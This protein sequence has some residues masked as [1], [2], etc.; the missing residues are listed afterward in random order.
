MIVHG[1][2]PEA[3][4]DL[5]LAWIGRH[6]LPPLED[7]Q[8]LVQS[9]G[10]AQWLK[11]AFARDVGDGG[12]GI[13]AGLQMSLPSRF[14]WTAYRAVLG[15]DTV[16]AVS[17]FDRALLT[18]RLMRLL[19]GL[20][21]EP[22]FEP[23]R[24]FLEEDDDL[25]KRHQLAERLADLFDQYQ[26][27]RADWLERWARGDDVLMT[28]RQGKQPLAASLRWQPRLWRALV[29]SV[30]PGAAASSRADVHRR[31]MA[32]A[33]ARSGE[34]P[35]GLPPR[36]VVF[37][38]SSLPQQSLEALAA[39]SRWCQVLMCV[40]NPCEHDWS[41]VVAD[42][43]LLRAERL[44]HR[45]RPGGEG[46][47]ADERLHLHAQPLLAAW[48]KQGRDFIRLLDMHDERERYE[49]RFA[50]IGQ[51]IDAFVANDGAVLLSQVQDDIRDLRPLAETRERWPAVDP[52]TDGSIRFHVAHSAQREVEI[53]H[54]QL[55]AAFAADPTLRARDV[56]VM[57][58]D[59]ASYA[60]HVQAVFGLV[61]RD[62]PRYLPFT[63]ADQGQRR[64]DPL[65]GAV[66]RLLH[67]PESR[68]AISDVLDLLDVP[69]VRARFGIDEAQLPLLRRWITSAGVRWGLH[70]A[71]R[72]TLGLPGQLSANTWRAGL[73]RMLLGYAV[74][75]GEAW[76]GIVPM[77]EVGGLDAVLL[78]PLVRLV[79]TLERHWSA[80]CTPA[81]P[82]DWGTRLRALLAD[83]F[84]P[85]RDT[86][87]LTLARMETALQDW[88]D[89]C[90]AAALVEPLTLAVAREHWLAQMD[91]SGLS[92]A[93]FAGAVT[94]ATLMPMRAIPFR[95]VALLGMNGGE[96]P[97]SR[98]PMDFDLMAQ[99]WRPGDRS[100]RE[101]DRY[102][103]LEALLSARDHLHVSWVGRSIVD[104]DGRP[105]SVLVAQL[106]DHLAAG[107]RL[108]GREEAAD[109]VA[110]LDA[111]T[112]E[113]PLQPFNAAYFTASGDARL[114]SYASEWHVGAAAAAAFAPED[115]E[116]PPPP[117]TPTLTLQALSFFLCDPVR[118]FFERR[119]GVHFDADDEAPD[120]HEPFALDALENWKLQDEL[121]ATQRSALESG[122]SRESALAA[123][124]HAMA[125]RG[126]LP[127]GEFGTTVQAEL[128]APME[129]L[130]ERHARALADW[131]EPLRDAA[132]GFETVIDGTALRL[133]D[134]LGDLRRNARGARARVLLVSTGLVKDKKYRRD[135]LLAWWVPHL[136]GHLGGEPLTTVLVSKV[137][138]V[139]LP[140]LSPEAALECWMALLW[141]WRESLRRP[142]PLTAAT[143][144]AW[145]EKSGSDARATEA[146]RK[147]YETETTG[148]FRNACLA[149]AF[150]DFEALV[151]DGEFVNL[152][153][154][155][156][157]PLQ[158]ALGD[159]PKA[160]SPVG[161]DA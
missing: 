146:A 95:R 35:A 15:A 108:A 49:S 148:N 91:Q 28:S 140:P 65:L 101:D 82:Q 138:T 7:E 68:I 139:T 16:P 121:I 47:I 118:Y 107:W 149:R 2:Q 9:N 21:A 23:L 109:G 157:R 119:L 64:H 84:M 90:A 29:E 20:L 72:S 13:A 38:I 113:H 26:V 58:P 77:D 105:P 133:D 132:V 124:L 43:D 62:D 97:R 63:I 45:R 141:A 8:I 50:E 22:E 75:T 59:I 134:W 34:R 61:D 158:Q 10:V 42:K 41:H 31:F 129:D 136:A 1:N 69:A 106:R 14:M 135:K 78:G 92:S 128:A 86:D 48:G 145:L 115:A 51:R 30:G 161:A 89:A 143:G 46:D 76:N 125:M 6:P 25:R 19:P 27:Y 85:D 112:I 147:A 12:A 56:I 117:R 103:F 57:V 88:L 131:P 39:L 3:L 53:L 79:D 116:L 81:V 18:W 5:V 54:D 36:L 127:V 44:R 71:Q 155:L 126:D 93:F 122:A 96:Y 87:G 110:L 94:F 67:L 144:F 24:R 104:N 99:D 60:P 55:L 74:G 33:Q 80:L 73:R 37:G 4:R 130:F 32:T 83:F 11:L 111:L 151:G 52:G 154:L 123:R 98:P 100:R 66:E 160:T 40:H 156:L 137:G 120:D 152:V 17:P 102:L 70:A 153:E 114:F 150:P 159:K 142:L